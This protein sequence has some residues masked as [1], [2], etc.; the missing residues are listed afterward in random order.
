MVAQHF[1][2]PAIGDFPA[3]ALHD[4]AFQFTFQRRQPRKT[5]FDL[6]QLR[7]GDGIGAGTGLVG[8]VRQAEEVADRL[9]GKAEGAGV[10]DEGEAIQSRLP[11]EPLVAGASLW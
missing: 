10:A 3:C 7:L 9:K 5:A 2:H 8:L 6:S 1:D 11:V 4:H